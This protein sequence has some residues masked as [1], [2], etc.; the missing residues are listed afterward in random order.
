M[1]LCQIQYVRHVL[2]DTGQN[3]TYLASPR[4][5]CVGVF[6]GLFEPHWQMLESILCDP[7][8]TLRRNFDELQ[9]KAESS[10]ESPLG[11]V[12]IPSACPIAEFPHFETMELIEAIKNAGQDSKHDSAN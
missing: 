6:K 1:R 9:K 4:E 5:I 7:F 12:R 10:L 3:G 11:K 2:L 8:Q